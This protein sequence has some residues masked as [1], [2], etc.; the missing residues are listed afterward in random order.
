MVSAWDGEE[1]EN[2]D[3]NVSLVENMLSRYHRLYDIYHD[4]T[5]SNL[6]TVNGN[7]GVSAVKVAPEIIDLLLYSKEVYR[8][9]GGEV[10]VMMGAVL[11]L[12]HAARAAGDYVP[13]EDDLKTAAEH[14]S[15]DSLVIDE[16]AGTVYISDPYASLD[17][18]AVAKGYAT[19]KIAEALEERGA[20]GYSLNI[21]GNI[22]LIGEKSESDPSWTV[23]ITNPDKNSAEYAAMLKLSDTS[24]VTSGDYE[25]TYTVGGVDYHHIIDR[26][27][28]YP[29]THFSSVSIVTADSALADA[30]ST[31]LF[32]MSEAEGC[33]LISELGGVEVLWIDRDGRVTMTDGMSALLA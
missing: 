26:D 33:T 10:N 17:V 13:T 18:G 22:R 27:T 9:T 14:T 29:S 4:Y 19:E 24:L 8:M 25:R 20:L 32:C 15:I 21:G 3:E 23:G 2:F 12:W 16:A 5:E 6:K 11:R 1:K 28:L 30:L 31:A 7:A